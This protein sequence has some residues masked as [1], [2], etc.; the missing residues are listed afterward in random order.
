MSSLKNLVRL[1]QWTLDEKRQTL[2]ELETLHDKL[3]TDLSG[4]SAQ[5]DHERAVAEKSEQGMAAYPAFVAVVLERRRKLAETIEKVEASIDAARDEVSLAYQ[6]LK[7]YELAQANEEKR[8]KKRQERLE[9]I[10][11][12][13]QGAESHRRRANQ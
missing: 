3:T 5:M 1:H 11:Q 12:D 6:E 10:L 13:E 2:V 4:L 8:E 9:Q 7:K